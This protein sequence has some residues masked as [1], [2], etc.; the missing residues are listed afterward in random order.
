M[1]EIG[2]A[3]LTVWLLALGMCTQPT[4]GRCMDGWYLRDGVRS[5]TFRGWPRGSYTCA[6]P[7]IGG[8]TDVLT[9]RATAIDRPGE[10][11]GRI[12]C[13]GRREIVVDERTVGCQR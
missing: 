9:G 2:C 11:T 8:D 3:L 5:D 12:H 7:P 1:I 10:Y 13:G 4:R 6:R